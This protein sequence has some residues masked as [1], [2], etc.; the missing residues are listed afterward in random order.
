[1]KKTVFLPLFLLGGGIYVL[2][3]KLWRGYS[4]PSMFFL[5]GACFHLMGAVDKHC[6]RKR[7]WQRCLLCALLITAAEFVCGCVVNLYL[8]LQVWDYR[9]FRT[10]LFGQICLPYTLLW[11]ALSIIGMPLYRR[12]YAATAN[13]IKRAGVAFR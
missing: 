11:G 12:L 5:G 9:R 3:E 2:L 1:M 6:R 7:L 13:I 8:K 4:H 10:N